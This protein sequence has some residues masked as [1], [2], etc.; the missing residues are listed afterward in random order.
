MACDLEFPL[1]GRAPSKNGGR[2]NRESPGSCRDFGRTLQSREGGYPKTQ[3]QVRP[4]GHP[5]ELDR[6]N[7]RFDRIHG[8]RRNG[9]SG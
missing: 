7:R 3:V 9:G 5:A 2:E 1:P 8:Y 4:L 6:R